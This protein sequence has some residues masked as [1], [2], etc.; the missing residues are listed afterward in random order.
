[1]KWISR[2]AWARARKAAARW[3]RRFFSARSTS[4]IVRPSEGIRKSGS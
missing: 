1:L 4:A 3:E 2:K